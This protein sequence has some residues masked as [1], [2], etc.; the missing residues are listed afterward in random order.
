MDWNGKD[1]YILHLPKNVLVDIETKKNIS[2]KKIGKKLV[3]RQK[4]AWKLEGRQKD[5]SIYSFTL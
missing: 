3:S 1:I 2:T 5:G 4:R